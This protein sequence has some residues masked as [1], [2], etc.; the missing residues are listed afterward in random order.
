MKQ[1]TIR[2]EEALSI[3]AQLQK[4]GLLVDDD[5]R[6]KLKL[7]SNEYVRT[8]YASTF[9]LKIDAKTRVII[10]FRSNEGQQSGV[11]LEYL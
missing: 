5:T 7:A 2:V 6:L 4:L 10:H 3:R 9:R 11:V 1:E 8:G